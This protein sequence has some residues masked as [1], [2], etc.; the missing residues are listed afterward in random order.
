MS[1][2][3][4][5]CTLKWISPCVGGIG[6]ITATSAMVP[7]V[8]HSCQNSLM[9]SKKVIQLANVKMKITAES[10][11]SRIH[12]FHGPILVVILKWTLIHLSCRWMKIQLLISPLCIQAKISLQ[13]GTHEEILLCVPLHQIGL[14]QGTNN[15]LLRGCQF[16]HA[17]PM[18]FFHRRVK[19]L[20]SSWINSFFQC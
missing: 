10:L 1:I 13:S 8:Y 4:I 5:T 20:A 7:F 19:K 3:Y 14:L 9:E 15:L 18:H 16:I 6:G 11:L 2:Y 12:S 17:S